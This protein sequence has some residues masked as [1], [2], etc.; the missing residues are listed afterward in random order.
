MQRLTKPLKAISKDGAEVWLNNNTWFNHICIN[1][2]ELRNCLQEVLDTI[3]EPIAIHKGQNN[4]Y[5]AFRWSQKRGRFIFVLY[6]RKGKTGRVKTAYE[7]P[8]PAPEVAGLIKV[9]PR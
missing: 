7:T 3:T 9:Y 4:T 1:H 2:P 5:F 6:H 8:D